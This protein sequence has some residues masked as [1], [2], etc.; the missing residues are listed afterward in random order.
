[1][2]NRSAGGSD[3]RG[4]GGYSRDTGNDNRSGNSNNWRGGG[5]SRENSNPTPP[6]IGERPRLQ[7]K[8]RT[9]PAT[10]EPTSDKN[11][12]SQS[13][14]DSSTKHSKANPFGS[15]VAVDTG[16]QIAALEPTNPVVPSDVSTDELVS[17]K[18]KNVSAE[19]T[20]ISIKDVT[21]ITKVEETTPEV[22][23]SDAKTEK[24]EKTRREPDIIN[25]R[26]AAF[27]ASN[28]A[29]V[30]RSE[31]RCQNFISSTFS[32]AD[33]SLN[34]RIYCRRPHSLFHYRQTMTV[35]KNKG[36]HQY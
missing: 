34:S 28:N 7:L 9:A 14:S 25:S 36:R 31:V 13:R 8:S 12:A 11:D 35:V 6:L 30:D 33:Q 16:S 20:P 22:K 2:N 24:R 27:G 23:P 17:E 26:A 19:S 5:N 32:V 21:E 3:D 1:M 4:A 15:A 18:A 10:T 29:G